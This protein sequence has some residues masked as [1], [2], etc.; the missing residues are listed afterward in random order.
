MPYGYQ[1]VKNGNGWKLEADPETAE[2]VRDWALRVIAGE[3]TMSVAKSAGRHAQSLCIILRAAPLAGLDSRVQG[4]P[5]LDTDTFEKLQAALDGARRPHT[6]R[7]DASPLLGTVSC[8]CGRQLFVQIQ[9][10]PSGKRYKYAECTARCGAKP[11]RVADVLAAVERKMRFY[12]V[13]PHGTW[14]LPAKTDLGR[15][16]SAIKAAIRALDLDDPDY[17]AK[18][19]K[20]RGDL[21]TAQM[22]PAEAPEPVWVADGPTGRGTGPRGNQA[23]HARPRDDR[24]HLAGR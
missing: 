19:D 17:D 21:R 18:H 5:V 16:V 23:L 7:H 3:S 24:D 6:K 4:D 8:K 13:L 9:S 22:T 12:D 15:E 14:K 11:M 10:R 1:A 2:V 20:L